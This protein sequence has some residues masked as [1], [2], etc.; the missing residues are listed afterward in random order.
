MK[1]YAISVHLGVPQGTVLAP[2]LILMCI[3]GFLII[4]C[5]RNKIRMYADDV[6]IY[7]CTNSK[8][9]LS[10]KCFQPYKVQIYILQTRKSL[11]S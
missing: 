2:S 9:D 8:D 4:T 1:S 5:V 11:N 6:L 10:D 7:S 3:N